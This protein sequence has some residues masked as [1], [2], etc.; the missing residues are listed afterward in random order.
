MKTIVAILIIVCSAGAFGKQPS[1]NG[2]VTVESVNSIGGYGGMGIHIMSAPSIVKYINAEGVGR[3]DDWG[4]A[5]EFFGGIEIP[6][7]GSWAVKLEHTFLFK[8]YTLGDGTYSKALHY[9]VQAPNIMAQYVIPGKGYF[10]KCSAGGGY[11][12]GTL[13]P[14]KLY[15][16][17]TLFRASGV[18]MRA[19]AE[20]QTAFDAHLFGYISCSLGFEALG[21]VTS[22]E[23]RELMNGSGTVSLNYV[24]AGVRF[25]LMYYF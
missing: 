15:G 16:V 24:T 18:G 20:G 2:V 1:K 13:T 9:D 3:V 4:T 12:W 7:N 23:G 14:P 6:V 19:E 17:E 5:V 22:A 11:H 8:S 25:G 10:V 21:K